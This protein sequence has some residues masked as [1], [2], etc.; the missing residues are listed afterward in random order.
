MKWPQDLIGG[1]LVYIFRLKD[2]ETE[3]SCQVTCRSWTISVAGSAKLETRSS[4][5]WSAWPGC[6]WPPWSW[7]AQEA[8]PRRS[9]PSWKLVRLVAETLAVPIKYLQAQTWFHWQTESMKAICGK[10]SGLHHQFWLSID[11]QISVVSKCFQLSR[12]C[13]CWLIVVQP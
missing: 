7:S 5:W 4:P 8:G 9:S 12:C 11:F 13:N 1:H 10:C 3:I 2:L 6:R